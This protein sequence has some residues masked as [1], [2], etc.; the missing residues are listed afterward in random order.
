M[1]RLT[2]YKIAEKVNQ[3][4][5]FID[6]VVNKY[7]ESHKEINKK[8]N[9]TVDYSEN[10]LAQESKRVKNLLEQK[11]NLPLAGVPVLVK[12]NICTQD[13]RT[14]CG[15][16]MLADYVAPYDAFV[17]SKLKEAGALIVGKANMDEFAMGSSN[18][19]SSYGPVKNPWDLDRVPGGS[20]GGSA[21][22]VAAGL[23]PV[24]LGSDTGGSIRQPAAFCGVVGS[25][26]TYGSV[27]RYG[28]IAF[29]SS[30]DQVGPFTGNVEDAQLVS[31]VIYGHDPRDSTSLENSFN[32][33]EKA[34]KKNIPKK[35]G[36]I[37]EFFV[38][39]LNDDIAASIEQALEFYKKQGV[40]IVEI[41]MPTIRNSIEM[42]YILATAEA[43]ANL[44]RF[45]GVRYGFRVEGYEN[46]ADL[47]E[48]SRSEGFGK[49]VKQRIMLGT[50]VLSSGYVDAFYGKANLARQKL[51]AEFNK[52]FSE[53]DFLLAPTSPTTA[54]KIGEK[55][56]D[57][58][59]MYLSD[60]YT[61]GVNLAGLPAVSVP[62]G[63]CANNLP[64]GMQFIGPKFSDQE[65]LNAS[66]FFQNAHDWQ[67]R[68]PDEFK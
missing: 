21:A 41:S 68:T 30:L 33:D 18:E 52:V 62:C 42:Y 9:C 25:K 36:I 8:L 14:T 38:D 51:S 26:P 50:Y 31:S 59:A 44:A 60:I 34:N 55:T 43:S 40:E 17:V 54:F 13:L 65:I 61:I 64:I 63:Y 46:I 28:L 24:A 32:L 22:A 58:L 27:S 20:S 3:D 16:K 53:V 67:E 29:A 23:V 11:S 19:N 45:D 56:D 2:A 39:E 6:V 1:S 7:I 66:L 12:D 5:G 47:Y 49:E 10:S 37:K 57:P 15:S 35:I 48:R 4:S